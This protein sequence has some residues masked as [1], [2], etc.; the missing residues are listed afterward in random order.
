MEI[1]EFS[2][3]NLIKLENLDELVNLRIAKFS[4]NRIRKIENI[5]SN[6]KLGI[7]FTFFWSNSLNIEEL[8]LESNYIKLIEGVGNLFRLKKLELGGNYIKKI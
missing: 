4:N 3:S 2:H 6:L 1:I 5:D 7:F 8:N